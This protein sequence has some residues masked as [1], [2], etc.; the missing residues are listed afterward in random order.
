MNL[1]QSKK[2]KRNDAGLRNNEII[3][4]EELQIKSKVNVA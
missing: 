2:K 4:A 3:Y 1:M